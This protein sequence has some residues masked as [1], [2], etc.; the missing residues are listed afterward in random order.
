MAGFRYPG[1]ER[2]QVELQ[3]FFAALGE[4]RMY[5]G[6]AI[7]IQVPVA[8]FVGRE[9]LLFVCARSYLMATIPWQCQTGEN[10]LRCRVWGATPTSS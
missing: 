4:L 5:G 8:V 1:W 7:G 6:E 10:A 9:A 2:Y 3:G